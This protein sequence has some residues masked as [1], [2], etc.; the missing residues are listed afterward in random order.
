[1]WILYPFLSCIGER[2]LIKKLCRHLPHAVRRSNVKMKYKV[3]SQCFPITF[4]TTEN[5]Y[6]RE[7]RN[8]GTCWISETDS[9]VLSDFCRWMER[10]IYSTKSYYVL[11]KSDALILF[12]FFSI[13][14]CHI[15]LTNFM[16][17]NFLSVP[18]KCRS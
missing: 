4:I 8:K 9:G 14:Q 17:S 11:V 16:S 3:S 13:P 18:K 12:S 10:R 5:C 7:I 1:M 15:R 2:I 6:F